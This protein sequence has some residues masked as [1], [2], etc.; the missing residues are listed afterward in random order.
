LDATVLGDEASRPRSLCP[1]F[2]PGA[3]TGA[4]FAVNRRHVFTGIK[5]QGVRVV[6]FVT[7]LGVIDPWKEKESRHTL[8]K[9]AA[10]A[11]VTPE[12]IETAP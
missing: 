7:P 5:K 3:S 2:V 4:T 8:R 1:E 6:E 12:R 10:S 11:E 9:F